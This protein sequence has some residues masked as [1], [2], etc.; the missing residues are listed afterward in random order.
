MHIYRCPTTFSLE[1]YMKALRLAAFALIAVAAS[2]TSMATNYNLGNITVPGTSMPQVA[3]V[4]GPTFS[5]TFQFSFTAP[6]SFPGG[7]AFDYSPLTSTILLTNA[8]LL[9]SSMNLLDSQA[10]VQTF[11][12]VYYFGFNQISTGTYYIGLSGTASGSGNYYTAQIA[13]VPEPGTLALF[14]LG[15][16]GAA[17]AARR[18]KAVRAA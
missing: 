11:P 1:T 16:A 9:D 2:A 8:S 7:V 18:G 14:G 13:L 10:M 15:L 4:S 12:G 5:D 3:T 17:F 6:F